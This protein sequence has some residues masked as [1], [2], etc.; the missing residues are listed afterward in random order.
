MSQIY[1]KLYIY[2]QTSE[3]VFGLVFKGMIVIKS[4]SRI[5]LLLSVIPPVGSAKLDLKN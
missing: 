4:T 3:I 1:Y 5:L 2:V